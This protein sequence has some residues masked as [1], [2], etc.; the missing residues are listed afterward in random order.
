VRWRG[1]W[2]ERKLT[3][4]FKTPRAKPIGDFTTNQVRADEAPVAS[5]VLSTFLSSRLARAG[6]NIK[7]IPA[8]ALYF[9][10]G[11]RGRI[12]G[13]IFSWVSSRAVFLKAGKQ[14]SAARTSTTH[15]FPY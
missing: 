7:S 6:V 1:P 5:L 13:L 15:L 8:V 2:I 12:W 3:F 10:L 9:E 14:N 11:R 4:S